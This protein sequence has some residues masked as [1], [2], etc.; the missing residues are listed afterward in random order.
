MD[1]VRPEL[2]VARKRKR[3]IIGIIVAVA[4]GGVTLGIATLK[5]ASPEVE[6]SAVVID[7]VKRGEMLRQV[8]GTGTLV[9]ESI[10]QIA[11]ATEGRV[12]KIIVRPGTVVKADTVLLELSNPEV[13]QG[14]RDAEL[15]LQAAQADLARRQVELQS[16][17]LNQKAEAA[18]V[19]ADFTEAKLRA[20]VDRD[21]ANNGL[22]SGLTVKLSSS[23]AEELKIRNEIEEQRLVMAA[24]AGDAQLAAQRARVDQLRALYDLRKSQFNSLHVRAG[25]DGVLQAMAVEI[26]Q[27]VA[28]GAN[29]ARVAEP[30]RLKA[31][32]RIPETQMRDVAIGQTVSIDTRNGLVNGKVARIDPASQEGS[33]TVDVQIDGPLPKGARP[34]LTVDGTIELER[35]VNVLYVGHPVQAADGAT[36]GLFKLSQDGSEAVRTIVGVGRTSV[37]FV[38]IRSGLSE[39]DQVILSDMSAWDSAREVRIK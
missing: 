27:R 8:R 24:R 36:I 25:I 19:R 6:R 7:T 4:T 14:S 13:E 39:G 38:E 1:I 26:G 9:P 16:E 31:Q 11:A 29:L 28:N 17:L 18:R 23:R 3:L 30:Q 5:P 37:N 33:V 2:A 35:L 21:L 22:T 20:D 15:Q 32:L 12:E 34:D 10:R